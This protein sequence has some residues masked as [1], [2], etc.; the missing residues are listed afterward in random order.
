MR[1]RR[2]D[3]GRFFPEAPRRARDLQIHR[4]P[5]GFHLTRAVVPADRAE[6]DVEPVACSHR[7]GRIA[8]A[9]RT[10][11]RSRRGEHAGPGAA[12]GGAHRP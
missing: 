3:R 12:A 9:I 1:V 2:H 6:R 10:A 8:G 7:A 5:A 4:F 11:A